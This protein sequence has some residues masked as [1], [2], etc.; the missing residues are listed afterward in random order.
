M[1]L[2]PS[3]TACDAAQLI[4][5]TAKEAER[6]AEAQLAQA[7]AVLPTRLAVHCRDGHSAHAHALAPLGAARGG[8]G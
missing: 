6:E 8:G 7:A 3:M 4:Q 1:S 5:R 2:T